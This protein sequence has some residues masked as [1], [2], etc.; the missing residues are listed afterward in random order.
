MLSIVYVHFKLEEAE[1]LISLK[2]HSMV[3]DYF[4]Q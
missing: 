1:L 4:W 3:W 2:V